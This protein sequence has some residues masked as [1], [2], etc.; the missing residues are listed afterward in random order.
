MELRR[1]G[2]SKPGIESGVEEKPEKWKQLQQWHIRTQEVPVTK[3][4][5]D[6]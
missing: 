2:H 5:H 1:K 3:L 6:F 4:M